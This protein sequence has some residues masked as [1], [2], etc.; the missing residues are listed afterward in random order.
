MI[1]KK[2]LA[3]PLSVLIIFSICN[4]AFAISEA[5]KSFLSMYFSEE[6]LV[7]VSAT[8][9]LKSIT[10]IAENIEVVTKEDIELMNAHTVADALF[11]TTGLEITGFVG[12]GAQ[13][14]IGIQGSDW[15]RVAVFLDGVPLGNENNGTMSGI[16]P[17]QMIDDE[18]S[19]RGNIHRR[20]E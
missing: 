20:A 1:M 16:L 13:G 7:V 6:E 4:N 5:E 2:F 12:P 10:R 17:V 15:T 18:A 11:F 19:Q 8:R 9:S 3:L 14:D